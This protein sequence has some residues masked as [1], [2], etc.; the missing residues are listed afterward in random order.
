MR[1]PAI[2][3]TSGRELIFDALHVQRTYLSMIEGVPTEAINSEVVDELRDQAVRLWSKRRTHVL[4]PEGSA[5]G[6]PLPAWA[7]I[8]W[9]TSAPI[10]P[11][12]AD[13]S[14]LVVIWFEHSVFDVPLG[15]LAQDRLESLPWETLA[16]DCVQ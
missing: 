14:E 11:G 8:A 13:N 9:L 15:A 16:E 3:L 7:C 10:R 4:H 6:E 5:P 2:S 12:E 1:F